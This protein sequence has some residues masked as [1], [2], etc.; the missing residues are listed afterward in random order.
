MS[1]SGG[2]AYNNATLD[3]N[4]CGTDQDTGQLIQTCSSSDAVA[5][6]GARLPYTPEF[7]GYVTARYTMPIMDWNAYGQVSATYQ[8]SNH[9]GLRT[10]DDQ[11]LG[12]MPSY[13]TVDLSA[14]ASRHG[15]T[16]ELAVKNLTDSRGQENRF[17]TCP[18]QLCSSTISQAPHSVYV[19]PIVPRTIVFKVEQK[20]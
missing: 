19:T 14:G 17:T 10:S 12:V 11:E 20:F 3:R 2:A 18:V 4:F 13:G 6:K 15:V 5:A 8:T 9:V 16:F 1:L 7:K